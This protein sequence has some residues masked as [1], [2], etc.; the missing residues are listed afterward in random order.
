MKRSS[1]LYFLKLTLKILFVG[2]V[3]GSLFSYAMFQGGFVSWFLFYTTTVLVIL[4]LLYA[5]VPLGS[6]KVTREVE[7]NVIAGSE[8]TV[9][10]TIRRRLPFPFLYLSV[11]DEVGEELARILPG[12]DTRIIFYP[13]FKR[14]LVYSYTVPEMKRGEYFFYGVAMETSDMFGIFHKRKFKALEEQLLVYPNYH[15]IEKWTAYEKHETETHISSMDFIED[16][17]SVA[18][19]REYVPGDKLT[20]IDWKVTARSSKLMTK[21]FEEFLGQNFLVI[22]NNNL[23][24]MNSG[25]YTAYEKGIELV[26]SLTLHA[27]R[28]QLKLG[29]WTLGSSNKAFPVDTGTAHQKQIIYHLSKVQGDFGVDFATILKEYEKSIPYGTTLFIVSAELTDTML[30][31]MRMLLSRR[32]QVYFCLISRGENDELEQKRFTQLRRYGAEAYILSGG[33][34]DEAMDRAAAN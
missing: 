6:F 28:K 9:T 13:G 10:V 5:A 11:K 8:L 2:A 34:L 30:E 4:M 31:T 15:N 14:E 3:F 17:T 1:L 16:I 22:F 33:D 21:E 32:N 27:N 26:T 20:S 29:L 24:D 7:D 25:S 19:A 18:G 23:P 12:N